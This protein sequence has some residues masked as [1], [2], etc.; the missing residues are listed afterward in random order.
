VI[1]KLLGHS[2][3]A[4]MSWYLDHLTTR[5]RSQIRRRSTYRGWE[6]D[7]RRKWWTLHRELSWVAGPEADVNEQSLAGLDHDAR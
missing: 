6:H 3:I 7:Q 4:V 5:A 2:S 1:S